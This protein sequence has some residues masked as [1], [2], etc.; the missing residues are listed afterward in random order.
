MNKF[1][2]KKGKLLFALPGLLLFSVFVIYPMIPQIL[3][4]FQSHNGAEALGYVGWN[5]YTNL[6]QSNVF[7]KVHRNTYF[8]VGCSLLIALPVSLLLAL[9]LER[10]SAGVRTVFKFGALFPSVLS[11]TVIGKMWAG[12]YD[13]DWGMLNSILRGIGM[14]QLTRSWLTNADTVVPCIA[15]AFLWQYIGLN[16]ILF[17]AG[18]KAIPEQYYEAAIIDGAGFW[19]ASICITIPLLQDIIKYVVIIST[20]GSMGMYA[21]ILVMTAGGPGDASRSVLYQMYYKAFSMSQFGEGCAIAVIF[22]I[23]CIIVSIIINKCIA[24]EPIQY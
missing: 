11:V 2:T 8:I 9:L 14:E 21:H 20:L 10:A 16:C 6:F 13:A 24:K 4:S 5:N 15:A 22:I 12:I 7:G 17:Y 3:I 1:Y 18:I 19:R 23:E